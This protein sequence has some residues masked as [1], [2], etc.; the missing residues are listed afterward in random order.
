VFGVLAAVRGADQ[1]LGDRAHPHGRVQQGRDAQVDVGGEAAIQD[2]LAQTVGVALAARGEAHE[3]EVDRLAE[4]V[5]AAAGEEDVGEMRLHLLDRPP[6]AGIVRIGA[7]RG[8]RAQLVGRERGR[9]LPRQRELQLDHA[10]LEMRPPR[11]ADVA[12]ELK[13]ALVLRQHFRD[14]AADAAR[15][16]RGRQQ[17]EQQRPDAPPLV[18]VLDLEGDLGDIA[19][20]LAFVARDPDQPVAVERHQRLAALVVDRRRVLDLARGEVGVRREVAEVDA[21]L[22]QAAVQG[23]EGGRVALPDRAHLHAAAIREHLLAR[24]RERHHGHRPRERRS[25]GVNSVRLRPV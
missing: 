2:D 3:P 10:A 15:A 14:E 5:D 1:A 13:H 6:G 22:G 11:E 23:D 19:G 4:L 12:Q 17:L 16:R 8:E 25:T 20:R 24:P 21:L 18:G 7:R 9:G